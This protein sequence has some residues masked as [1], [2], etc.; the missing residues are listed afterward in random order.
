MPGFKIHITAST[1]LG[2]GYGAAANVI[3]PLARAHRLSLSRS[4]D[5]VGG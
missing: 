1:I 4:Y 2:V 5:E 3:V